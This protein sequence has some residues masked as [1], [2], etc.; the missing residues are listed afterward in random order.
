MHK[1]SIDKPLQILI[2]ENT[3]A[4]IQAPHDVEYVAH[5]PDGVIV[6][7]RLAAKRQL[8]MYNWEGKPIAG[9]PSWELV[10]A[11]PIPITH[12]R[13]AVLYTYRDGPVAGL[14]FVDE[15]AAITAFKHL[16][17]TIVGTSWVII[18]EGKGL[19]P[20]G[21]HNWSGPEGVEMAKF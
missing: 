14:L 9:T 15:A 10:N 17:G 18:T 6:A 8:S 12:R 7:H 5:T 21:T 2:H 11:K 19:E 13:L 1:I 3:K 4:G 16:P 20:Y